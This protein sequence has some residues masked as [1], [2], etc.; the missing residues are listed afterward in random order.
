MAVLLL[1]EGTDYKI[2]TNVDYSNKLLWWATDRC[3]S[4]YCHK[5]FYDAGTMFTYND[6]VGQF[7]HGYLCPDGAEDFTIVCSTRHPAARLLSHYFLVFHDRQDYKTFNWSKGKFLEFSEF[8]EIHME[9]NKWDDLSVGFELASPISFYYDAC[10]EKSNWFRN[11]NYL[12]RA[13][14]LKEDFIE[15]QKGLP[16]LSFNIDNI[17]SF[18]NSDKQKNIFSSKERFNKKPLMEYYNE[19]MLRYM[20][21]NKFWKMDYILHNWNWKP[22]SIY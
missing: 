11:P 8:F 1:R 21:E 9:L 3:A 13:E 20:S 18:S 5:I 15:I 12:L 2:P 17:R 16:H 19:D 6:S 14:Y 10:K 22:E 4:R 7:N